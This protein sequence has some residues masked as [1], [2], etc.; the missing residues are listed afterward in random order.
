MSVWVTCPRESCFHVRS[1]RPRLYSHWLLLLLVYALSF[2][3]MSVSSSAILFTALYFSGSTAFFHEWRLVSRAGEEIVSRKPMEN[4]FPPGKLKSWLITSAWVYPSW[5]YW[6]WTPVVGYTLFEEILP[7][8][9]TPSFDF[10]FSG[11]YAGDVKWTYWHEY[12]YGDVP[13]EVDVYLPSPIYW[14]K[15]RNS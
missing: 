7:D 5:K 14:I 6:P 8:G 2:R 13:S 12:Y 4:R 15:I 1:N 9:V 3:V 10:V 11:I